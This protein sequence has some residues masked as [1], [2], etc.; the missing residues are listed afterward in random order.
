M[1]IPNEHSIMDMVYL[2]HDPEQTKR[3]ITAIIWDG[4]KVMYEMIAGNN[5]SQHYEFEVSTI[6]TIY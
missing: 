1:N 6:K 2:L 4:H 3:M 5:V